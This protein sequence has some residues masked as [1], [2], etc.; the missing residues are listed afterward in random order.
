MTK[1]ETLAMGKE[2]QADDFQ[3]DLS[4]N[5]YKLDEECL[6]HSNRY[7]YYA[8]AQAIA[9]TNVSEAKDKLELVEAERYEVIRADLESKGIKT[10][11]PMLDRALI[12]DEEVQKAKVELRDAEEVFV[13]LSVAI[14]AMD[15]RKSELDN[16]VK[17]Y[18]AGYFSTPNAS[19]S[20]SNVN[21]MTEKDIRKRLN[22]K[23]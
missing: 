20:R 21:E 4:I 19:G 5:K 6:S 11:I 2:N 9:K 14:S 17:L 18:C 7:A 23:E 3:K 12:I 22:D 1:A 10:T 8:E 15:A 16:L 13:R